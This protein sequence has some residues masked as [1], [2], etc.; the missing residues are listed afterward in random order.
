M[1]DLVFAGAGGF[2]HRLL[3]PLL[4]LCLAGRDNFG[5]DHGHR[6]RPLPALRQVF[7]HG[8]AGPTAVGGQCQSLARKGQ[9]GFRAVLGA[10][11]VVKAGQGGDGGFLAGD[12]RAI[13]FAGRG[14]VAQRQVGTGLEQLG[15]AVL[16]QSR[17]GLAGHQAGTGGVTRLQGHYRI[18]QCLDALFA[19]LGGAAASHGTGCA[20]KAANDR[21]D[22]D[23]QCGG[24]QQ[25][26]YSRAET[27]LHAVAGEFE[28]QR[29]GQG[30]DPGG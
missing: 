14:H 27:R 6:F 4:G 13:M 11:L 7:K 18:G 5:I 16:G 3:A 17:L 15:G 25:Q 24:D 28:R 21:P 20:D 9:G 8:F 22:C 10:R 2:D 1:A 23:N 19:A 12:E 29:A 26:N 30:D